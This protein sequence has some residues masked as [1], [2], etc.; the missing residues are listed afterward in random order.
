[1]F[2]E[3]PALRTDFTDKASNVNSMPR[4]IPVVG[5]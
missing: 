2:V 4:K 1:M 3:T 5:A